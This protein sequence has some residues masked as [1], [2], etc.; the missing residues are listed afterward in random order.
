MV[1]TDTLD[2]TL[3]RPSTGGNLGNLTGERT[4]PKLSSANP[5]DELDH[6]YTSNRQ[7]FEATIAQ[8][9]VTSNPFFYEAPGVEPGNLV[10]ITSNPQ[11]EDDP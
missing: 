2:L 10:E 1:R 11:G 7:R 3:T 5:A 8:S 6:T 9:D 4:L